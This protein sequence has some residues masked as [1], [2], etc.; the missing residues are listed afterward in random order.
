MIHL[1]KWIIAF[2]IGILCGHL[3]LSQSVKMDQTLWIES[4]KN[5]KLRENDGVGFLY[6]YN[7]P[8]AHGK[9]IALFR[10]YETPINTGFS[11]VEI[12]T[13]DMMP[14]AVKGRIKFSGSDIE[15]TTDTLFI[16][17]FYSNTKNASLISSLN[18]GRIPTSAAVLIISEPLAQF[19]FYRLDLSQAIPKEEQKYLIVQLIIKSGSDDSYY[20]G[21]SNAVIDNLRLIA[22]KNSH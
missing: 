16:T 7:L 10:S 6:P 14:K 3:A 13:L 15:R 12:K 19:E 4:D 2:L 21:N 20:Y 17:A 9:A 11:I 1:A 18:E 5:V 8:D 22:A